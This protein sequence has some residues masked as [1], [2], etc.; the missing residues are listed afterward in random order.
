MYSTPA[1]R[2]LSPASAK[3]YDRRQL[4]ERL[5]RALRQQRW[6]EVRAVAQQ[7]SPDQNLAP[8]AD[9]RKW[10]APLVGFAGTRQ[11]SNVMNAPSPSH[12][13]MLWVDAVGGFLVC[14]ADEIAI[15]QAAPIDAADVPIQAD[16]SR[17]H[18]VIRRDQEGYSIEPVSSDK[19]AR[20]VKIDG[21]PIERAATL[22]D[23]RMIELG[24][25]VRMRFRR[26]HPLSA[27]AR[28]EMVSHHR[29]QPATD[30]ILLMADS[31]I[32]GRGPQSHVVARD[33]ASEVVL[34]RQGL[35]LG[36]RSGS[37]L[38]INGIEYPRRGP[39][40]AGSRVQGEGFSFMLEGMGA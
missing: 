29:T 7:L 9:W 22:T 21:R 26:P 5:Q 3:M 17:R 20:S 27:T 33:L 10:I 36:C 31:C 13:Y 39:V 25:G 4:A 16:L 37:P 23:G 12:R 24:E 8:A 1:S 18:A 14:L 35:G 40:G 19:P 2:L 32:L 38:Q 11:K 28:L 6:S 30:G 34:F 15:G